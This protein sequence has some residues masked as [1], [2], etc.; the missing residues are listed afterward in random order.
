MYQER[1]FFFF[2]KSREDKAKQSVFNV[3]QANMAVVY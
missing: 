1:D 2:S 3:L